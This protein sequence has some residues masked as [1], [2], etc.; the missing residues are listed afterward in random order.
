[1]QRQGEVRESGVEVVG[2]LQGALQGSGIGEDESMVGSRKRWVGLVTWALQP[3]RGG[4]SLARR[5]CAVLP[6]DLIRLRH[7]SLVT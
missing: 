7:I 4:W 6:R 1:M 5:P 2:E 3:H